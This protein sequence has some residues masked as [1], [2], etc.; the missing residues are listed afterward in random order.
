MQQKRQLYEVQE[1]L[2]S[3]ERFLGNVTIPV[4]KQILFE[5]LG[6]D[7]DFAYYEVGDRRKLKDWYDATVKAYCIR[8]EEQR[9]KSV[10]ILIEVK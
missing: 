1:I 3:A 10:S 7:E 4:L 8:Q 9:T 2:Q 5:D 6:F